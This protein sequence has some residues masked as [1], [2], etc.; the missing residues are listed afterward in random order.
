MRILAYEH[1]SARGALAPPELRTEGG[2]MLAALA[3]DL[4]R[5]GHRVS[6]VLG[7]GLAHARLE[8][9]GR[10]GVE[11]LR[12]EGFRAALAGV[13]AVWIVAPETGGCLESLTRRAQQEGKRVLGSAPGAIAIAASKRRTARVLTGA[14]VPVVPCTVMPR[15]ALPLGARSWGYPLVVK[16]D[17][18]V[19]CEGVGLVRDA[20][21]LQAA[22][23]RARSISSR[24]L[25]QPYVKALSAS[26]SLLASSRGAIPLAL[27]AQFVEMEPHGGDGGEGEVACHRA[28]GP[29]RAPA[30]F[31][32]RGGEVPL[33]SS[34]A[35]EVKSVAG[36]ACDAVRGLAGFVGVDLLLGPA[37]AVVVEVNPRL[38]TAYL[39]LRR[40]TRVNI[41]AMTVRALDGQPPGRIRWCARVSY[42]TSGEVRSRP[43]ASSSIR[44]YAAARAGAPR[45]RRTAEAS[46]LE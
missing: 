5:A 13:E 24:V 12:G 38:T 17:D 16:P 23:S 30:R 20:A 1:F 32:Y 15:A 40:A 37:G 9:L 19:G 28:E 22:W 36:A 34:L 33:A 7:S 43:L 4:A 8:A 10:V 3:V 14:G 39:G 35:A 45:A 2:A 27:Q 42:A 11:I 44:P 18:G 21:E 6:T 41:A 25:V 29:Q 26:V 46:V 31:V